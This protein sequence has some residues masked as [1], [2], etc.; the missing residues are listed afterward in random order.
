MTIKP[1]Y[2]SIL[3]ITPYKPGTYAK[4]YE[5]RQ[6]KLSSNEN[7]LG[8]SPK[9][10]EAINKALPGLN[11]YPE[12]TSLV[13]REKIA[14]TYDLKHENIICGAG[15]DEIITLIC[16]AFAAAGKEV[17]HTKHG[18]LMY[19][20]SAL[21][22]GAK[23]VIA[24]ET[25][26]RADV[27]KILAK[28]TEA[29]KIVF[30]ANPNNPTGSYLRVD[31]VE[32]LRK[33]L[34]DDIILVLDLAYAEYADHLA[35]Y[36]SAEN[37]AIKHDNVIVTHTFSKIYGIP[38]LR[39]GW[40]YASSEIIDILNRVRG[41][42][43]IS[44]LAQVAGIAALEDNEFVEKSREHNTKWLNLLSEEL[45]NL[46][47]RVNPS[48]A[49]FVLTDFGSQQRA[50]KVDEHLKSNGISARMMHAYKLPSCIRFSIG[51]ED[52]NNILIEELSNA[53]KAL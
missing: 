44:S 21:A 10:S 33:E 9:V 51:L 3:E 37:F 22:T 1:A 30:V 15:S 18:F 45:R 5:G 20:I 31:E 25:G 13:L 42:F 35:D 24:E 14:E 52:E 47:L 7:P 36:P 17:I 27:D 32:R 2:N 39:L 29:T 38:A 8:Y 4:P 34:R 43:N 50:E 11:R 41:P 53:L 12:G 28:V 23:P 48:I 26:L 16:M 40:A 6:I 46:D 49:N 19:P